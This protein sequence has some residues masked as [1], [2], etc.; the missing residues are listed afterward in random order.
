MASIEELDTVIRRKGEKIVAS[1]PQL[2]LV[3]TGPDAQAAF[4]ALEQ[5]KRLLLADMKAAGV[6]DDF[7]I[8]SRSRSSRMQGQ[9]LRWGRVWE[10]VVKLA[11]VIV[12]VAAAGLVSARIIK[13]QSRIGGMQFWTKVEA[14]VA[15]A[16]DPAEDL[17]E[18][19]KKKLLS[20]L[21]VIVDRWKPFAAVLAPL[22]LALRGES[23][24]N[25]AP[26]SK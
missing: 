2:G 6:A 11:I 7:E 13:E 14:A 26:D 8:A 22:L 12:V 1:I 20:D 10:F 16:A 24:Q 21:R 3:A 9:G 17:P 23:P 5:K 25:P 4:L 18:A 19:K 15:R